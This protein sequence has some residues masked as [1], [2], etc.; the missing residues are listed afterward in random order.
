MDQQLVIRLVARS[1]AVLDEGGHEQ[2]RAAGV[3]GEGRPSVREIGEVVV[4]ELEAGGGG[5][6][7]PL[8][9]GRRALLQG[10]QRSGVT[11]VVVPGLGLVLGPV[12]AV[13][14]T[15]VERLVGA[16]PVHAG[17]RRGPCLVGRHRGARL[18]VRGRDHHRQPTEPGQQ[19]RAHPCPHRRPHQPGRY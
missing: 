9:A 12:V 10:Q 19:P 2:P 4:D 1:A 11:D 8:E 3:R 17:L 6:G 5:L 7:R 14:E 18:R 15:P 16:D 13:E